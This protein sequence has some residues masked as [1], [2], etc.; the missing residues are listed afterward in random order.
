MPRYNLLIYK[1]KIGSAPDYPVSDVN[2]P[3]T[4][5]EYRCE[6]CAASKGWKA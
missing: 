5:G 2:S 1:D 3:G 4:S 6:G